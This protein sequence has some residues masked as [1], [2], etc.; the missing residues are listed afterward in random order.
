MTDVIR[1]KIDRARPAVAEGAPGADRGW[2]LALARATRD[3]MGLDLDIRALTIS[4]FSLAEIL[5]TVPD[6]A[7]LALL[8]GPQ[9][10]LGVIM[11]SPMVTASLIEMQTL[12]RLS[13]QAPAPRRPS[14]IDAAMVAGVIDRALAGLD[15]TLAEEAD[16]SWA[17]GFRYASW[18][19]DARPLALML[20]EETYRVL[21]AEVAMGP[22]G[23]QGQV[24]LVLPDLGRGH[25]PVQPADD[26]EAAAPQFTQELATQVLQADCR[27][28]A[29]LGRLRLPLHRI[30][31]LAVGETLVL[32]SAALDAVSLETL[33]GRRVAGARLG[34]H[35]G[36]RALKLNETQA[37]PQVPRP[38]PA[39]AASPVA[40]AD[41]AAPGQPA[42]GPELRAAG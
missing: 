32:P 16:L 14:R 22:L 11:L 25:R 24:I 42:A 18:L 15:D 8:D 26:R 41:S 17:G 40:S 2:R 30:M 28:D 21:T 20:E 4:R 19:E 23:R 5:E 35:R 3:A 7:L 31:A 27:L 1:R 13:S 39:P 34:Q 10:G 33:E 36:M 12:G 37:V 29:V 9:G 6:R 38:A